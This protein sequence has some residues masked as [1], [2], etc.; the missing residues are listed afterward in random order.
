MKKIFYLPLFVLMGAFGN[1]NTN[2]PKSCIAAE[3]IYDGEIVRLDIQTTQQHLGGCTTNQEHHLFYFAEESGQLNYNVLN[4][5]LNNL[6]LGISSDCQ[7]SSS[8]SCRQL[9]STGSIDV[10]AGETIFIS[11]GTVNVKR[12]AVNIEFIFEPN[13]TSCGDSIIDE[14]EEC[15]PGDEWHSFCNLDTCQWDRASYTH[16]SCESPRAMTYDSDQDIYLANFLSDTFDPPPFLSED[17]SF[18]CSQNGLPALF[19]TFQT[20]AYE[21][22]AY[23]N[24]DDEA[25]A[26]TFAIFEG[27]ATCGEEFACHSLDPTFNNNYVTTELKPNTT[28]TIAVEYDSSVELTMRELVQNNTCEEAIEIDVPTAG[29]FEREVIAEIK[30]GTNDFR[31]GSNSCYY[32]DESNYDSHWNVYNNT[33][34]F[35][36]FTAPYDGIVSL[37]TSLAYDGFNGFGA[38]LAVGDCAGGLYPLG[39]DTPWQCIP[40]DVEVQAGRTYYVI[41]DGIVVEEYGTEASLR[42]EMTPL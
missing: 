34:M 38:F 9:Q 33:D 16:A 3:K 27:D 39:L 1:C 12:E 21:H 25:G 29:A 22:I 7:D 40:D 14:D 31:I 18:T 15:E 6:Q 8:W 37:E 32:F 24:L 28:Y 19:Y 42:L 5:N 17:F 30:A 20:P 36:K 41:F 11:I 35:Y 23:F 26:G 2:E 10:T 4:G 13:A